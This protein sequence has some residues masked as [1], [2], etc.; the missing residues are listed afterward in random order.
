MPFDSIR[1]WLGFGPASADAPAPAALRELMQ[2]LDDLEPE[3]ARYLARFAYL[4]G[5]IA[6][7]AQHGSPEEART[8]EALLVREGGLSPEQAVVAAGLAKASNVLFGGT[9]GFEV[10][11]EFSAA[12]TYEEKLALVRCLFAVAAVDESIS[13]A[14]ESAIHRVSI[15]FKILPQDL[16]ALRVGHARF[17]PG[18]APPRG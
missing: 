17:L 8:M 1:T 15:Q 6:H 4:L 9:A 7:A 5:R 18:L 2:T 12:A 14:E 13:V 16:T 10:A 3:R 11:Q